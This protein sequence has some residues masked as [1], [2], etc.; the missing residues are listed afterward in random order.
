M[1]E[2]KSINI[3]GVGLVKFIKSR[4]SRRITLRFKYSDHLIVT[5]PHRLS[6]QSAE[7]LVNEKTDWI[8]KKMSKA[9]SLSSL[10]TIFDLASNFETKHH[11]LAIVPDLVENP[12]VKVYDGII[13][14][15]YPENS[16]VRDEKTQK[17]IRTGI[18]KALKVEAE[19]WIPFRIKKFGAQHGFKYKDIRFKNART[20]WGS[21]SHDNN[22]N[23]N[24]HLMALPE[25]L[26]D[27]VILHELC[28]TIEKN[29]SI[30]FWSLMDRILNVENGGSKKIDKDLKKYRIAAW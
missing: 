9:P 15:R 3:D 29:H 28:H 10:R 21:C 2:S 5:I 24:I 27:Y 23:F 1:E 22:L 26:I 14:V 12:K 13:K 20:R 19:N 6:Y 30:R 18:E 7:D 25:Y 4:R 16:D 8:K 11:R 17:V